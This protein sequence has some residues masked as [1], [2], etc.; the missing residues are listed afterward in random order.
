[1]RINKQGF[2]LIE[3]L[4]VIAIIAILAGLIIA[5]LLSAKGKAQEATAHSEIASLA[6]L[7][8]LYEKDRG[9]YPP[10]VE[11]DSSSVL[12]FCLQGNDNPG[13]SPPS[14][15]DGS[16][17]ASPPA[18]QY[19]SFQNRRINKA[20]GYHE[21][22]SPVGFPYFYREYYSSGIESGKFNPTLAKSKVANRDGFDIWTATTKTPGKPENI[23]LDPVGLKALAVKI[24]NWD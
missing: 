7:F 17:L 13:W 8:S 12:V 2:T 6:Q 9:G 19:F 5:N 20:K 11:G 4:M 1:M 23:R 24:C 21:Y 15:I 14:P 16:T 3:L 22:E 10:S 18:K